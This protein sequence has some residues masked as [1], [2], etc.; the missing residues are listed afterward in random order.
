M[1]L[2]RL[3]YVPSAGIATGVAAVLVIVV[4]WVVE[5]VVELVDWVG[6]PAPIVGW[7]IVD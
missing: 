4:H 7:A 3:D 5:F 2:G 1:T 6:R